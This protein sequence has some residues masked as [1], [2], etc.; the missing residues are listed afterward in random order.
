MNLTAIYLYSVPF[1]LL[2][3]FGFIFLNKKK[4]AKILK[5]GMNL[6]L[7]S[8]SLP[9]EQE[10]DEKIPLEDYLKTA[11]NFFGSLYSFKDKFFIFEISVHRVGEEIYFYIAVPRNLSESVEKQVLSFWPKAEVS[12]VSDYNIFNPTGASV[13]SEASLVSPDILPLKSYIEFKTDPISSLTNALTKLQKDEEGASIQILFAPSKKKISSKSRKMVN[14]LLKGEDFGYS[15]SEARKGFIL[16]LLTTASK[17]KDKEKEEK[18]EVS[19]HQQQLANLIAEKSSKRLFDVNIRLLASAKTKERAEAILSQIE[20][21]FEQFN[22]PDLNQIKFKRLSR[23]RL[24][25]LFYLFSFRLISNTRKMV[26]SSSEMAGIFHFPSSGLATPSVKWVKSKQ[27]PPPSNLPD[28]GLVLGKS[29]FRG[30]EKTVRM[31]DE[32]RRRHFYIIGQTGTGK[33]WFLKNLIQ[34]DIRNGKGIALID[35]HGDLAEDVLSYIPPERVEDVIYFDPSDTGNP[36]GLNMLEYDPAFPES[37]TFVVNELMDI[38]DRL[39]NL[40]AQGFGGPIFEQYMRNSLLLI[41]EDTDSGS[42]LVEIPR[43]LADTNFRKHKLSKCQN[44]IV[45]NFW[46]LEAEKAGGDAALANMVPYI[47]SKMNVFIANDMVRPIISQQKSSLNLKDVM[48][49]RKILIANLSKG[50]M[51]DINSHLLG[52]VLVGKILV[53][54]FSRVDMPEEERKD[55][56]LYI[57]EFQNFATKTMASILAEARKYRLNMIFAH[58]YIGQV[59]EDIR[60]AVFGNV[61]SM[62]SFRIGPED[63]KFLVPSYDPIFDESDLSNLDNYNAALRLLIGGTVTRPFNI[64]TIPPD[65]GD[66]RIAKLARDFSRIKYGRKRSSVENEL[67]ERLGKS[68]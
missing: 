58:Q 20:V 26:L 36:I 14:L 44:Q 12:V 19:Q 38:F 52:M 68:Y 7:L 28:E 30:E 60:N 10:K 55:F 15:L 27:A 48:N 9:R 17:G 41:M 13:G 1:L 11:E 43:V 62:M 34:Q 45:K 57:D 5:Q 2:L 35:P 46:E 59:E 37:K 24:K 40:K 47:T 42:T 23:G 29:S 50:K 32:D 8:V 63:A 64:K 33:S 22:S 18:K 66:D 61:G 67:F 21:S 16:E 65:K 53:A 54:A 39:Y 3:I 25:N 4:D 31:K 56:Y 51:G 49:G 6:V